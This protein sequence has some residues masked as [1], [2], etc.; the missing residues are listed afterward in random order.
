M[1][2]FTKGNNQGNRFTR[3]KQPKNPGRKPSRFEQ[4]VAAFRLEDT[5]R[6][7]SKADVL[8]LM[9]YLLSCTKTEI[10]VMLRNPELP[11]AI[12][13][14][15][16]AMITD[17]QNGKTDTIDK[18]FDR[19]Y[20]KATTPMEITGAGGSPLIPDKPMSRKDYVKLLNDMMA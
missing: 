13:G 10:E 4:L 16:R 3:D 20:G 5:T 8:R 2:K 9:A 12:V 15:I 19:V 7:I 6:Q 14:Q 11:F 17:V 1:A 18:I